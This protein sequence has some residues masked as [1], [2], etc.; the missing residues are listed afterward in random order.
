MRV[1]IIY[2][3]RS[4]TTRRLAEALAKALQADVREIKC[5]RYRP[6]GLRYLKAGYDSLRGNLPQI[7]GPDV[8]PGQYDLLLL[9]APVWTS[10][11]ALPL[12]AYLAQKPALP[13]A[14]GGF[15][16]LGG[17]SPPAATFDMVADV[18]GRPLDATFAL[19][20]KDVARGGLEAAIYPFVS[21]LKSIGAD[22]DGT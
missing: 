14:V 16:T 13:G 17:Q 18:L 3:S 8:D 9:G 6:G 19:K 2:Y 20:D 21:R 12:R 5:P 1:L 22:K 15:V 4:G 11:P 10:Y 7:E